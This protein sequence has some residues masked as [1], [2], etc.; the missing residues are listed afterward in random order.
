MALYTN[1]NTFLI[2]SRSFLIKIWTVSDK[3]CG[4]NPNR[5]CVQ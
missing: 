2:I 5:F 1:T 3:S 4:E